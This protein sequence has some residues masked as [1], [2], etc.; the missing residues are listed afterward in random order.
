MGGIAGAL[1]NHADQVLAGLPTTSHV[2]VRAIFQRLVTPERTRAIVDIADLEQLASDRDDVR[3]VIDQLVAARLL[4]VQTQGAATVE[5]AHE[6]LLV[7]WPTLRRWLDEDQDD[8]ELLG[9]L[10]TAAKQWDSALRAPGLLWR[11]EV[12]EEARRWYAQRPRQLAAREQAFLDAV[13]ALARRGKRIR[14]IALVAT[15]AVLGGIAAVASIGYV[16]VRAAEQEATA[17]MKDATDAREAEQVE[18][19]RRQQADKDQMHALAMLMTEEQLRDAAEAGLLNATEL[20]EV[21]DARRKEAERKRAQAEASNQ[22]IKDKLKRSEAERLEAEKAALESAAEV[23]MT[24]EELIEKTKQLQAALAAAKTA[25]AKAETSQAEAER[26]KTT[27]EQ[28]LAT[29]KERA[30]RLQRESKKIKTDDLR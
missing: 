14:R 12:M 7:E 22:A 30:D 20:A 8:A 15:L 10:A 1:A 16:R 18:H 24:R 4:V 11:G 21:A 3:R 13:L 28:K 6:S 2:L 26:A 19:R 17:R 9:R 23:K 29:E 25:R 5:I 27:L